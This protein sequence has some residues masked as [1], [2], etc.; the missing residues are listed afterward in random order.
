MLKGALHIHS[1]YSDGEFTLREL[2]DVYLA[3]GCCFAC[4]TDHA[5]CFDEALVEAY[6]AECAALSDHR[7]TFVP[8]LEFPAVHRM[9]ILGYG[10]TRLTTASEPSAVVAHIDAC[11][12]VSV[13][14]HPRDPHFEWIAGLECLPQ[15]LEVWNSKYDG[16]YA[17]RARTFGLLRALQGRKPGLLAF[18]GQDLHWRTQYRGLMVQIDV[19]APSPPLI[20]DALRRGAFAGEKDGICLPSTGAVPEQALA[21]MERAHRRSDRLRAVLRSIKL[22]AD[23]LGVPVPAGLK[24]HARRVM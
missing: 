11:G 16:R 2:R 15:G 20:L 14:A 5:D 12:G 23:R 19:D 22:A 7:F 1:T 18:Y 13:I 8:G 24:A 6:V 10:V 17:P 21:G 9:H 4:V 3:D